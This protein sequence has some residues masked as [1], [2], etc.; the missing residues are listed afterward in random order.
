MKQLISPDAFKRSIS[1]ALQG[2]YDK[3]AALSRV[4]KRLAGTDEGI[5]H[6]RHDR[7]CVYFYE[8][9]NGKEVYI[10]KKTERLY[11]L[12]RRKYLCLLLHALEENTS[13]NVSLL[14]SLIDEF[15]DGNLNLAKIVMTSNQFNWFTRGYVKKKIDLSTAKYTNNNIPVRSK[16]ERDIGNALEELA[17]PYHHDEKQI[18]KVFP[19]VCSLENDLKERGLLAGTLNYIRGNTCLWRVPKE[20]EWMNCVGSIWRAYDPCSGNIIIYNDFKILLADNEMIY[21]EHEGM[22]DDFIYRANASEREIVL[23]YT[24]TVKRGNMITTF[25]K[26]VED[27]KCLRQIIMR[28]VLPRLWF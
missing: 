16:S 28:E 22:C 25:E 1:I 11:S 15:A 24:N 4:R 6:F 8:K 2:N 9:I 19:L 10:S 13:E 21:W 23:Q 7:G 3:T 18:I 5:L 12:A 27:T 14:L 20:L 17:V 26:E